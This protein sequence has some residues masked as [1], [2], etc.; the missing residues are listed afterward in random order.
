MS[1][2]FKATNVN[3]GQPLE[4]IMDENNLKEN[5]Y[6]RK[7]SHNEKISNSRSKDPNTTASNIIEN[8][9]MEANN[10]LIMANE[11]AQ[12]VLQDAKI[13][14]QLIKVNAQKEGYSEGYQQGLEDGKRETQDL[15]HQALTIKEELEEERRNLITNI[16]NEIPK[17][18]YIAVEK[19]I[20]REFNLNKKIILDIISSTLNK[21][22]SETATVRVSDE[23]YDIVDQNK[24]KVMSECKGLYDIEVKKDLSLDTGDCIVE[25]NCGYI[26]AGINTQIKKLQE[27]VLE[28]VGNDENDKIQD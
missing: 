9:S 18:I 23:D 25:T 14:A 24:D 21:T 12:K 13:E 19:V 1:K 28:L 5:I 8:A 11:D 22:N 27:S 3:M 10:I 4:V 6:K 16:E 20:N 2:I 17:I 26:D 15:A 7:I